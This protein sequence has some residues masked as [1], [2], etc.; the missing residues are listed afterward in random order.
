MLFPATTVWSLFSS[1]TSTWLS[2]CATSSIHSGS[3]VLFSASEL[4][5][6]IPAGFTLVWALQILSQSPRHLL[7]LLPPQLV[8]SPVRQFLLVH[9]VVAVG[10][11]GKYW[12]YIAGCQL[13]EWHCISAVLHAATSS[14]YVVEKGKGKGWAG[15]EEIILDL[16]STSAVAVGDD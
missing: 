16:V 6:F 3:P 2:V 9:F 7:M 8:S 13:G 1:F 14:W 10:V 12:V 4:P 5:D 15:N 11:G